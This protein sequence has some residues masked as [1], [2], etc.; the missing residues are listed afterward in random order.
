[1]TVE[2]ALT[3]DARWGVGAPVLV[4][5]A[6]R[7]G[8]AAVGLPW[9][10][11]DVD[12]RAAYADAGVRCHE[13]LALVVSDDEAETLPFAARLAE[14]AETVD[15]EWV[16]AVFRSGPSPD[17][18]KVVAQCAAMI[19]EAGSRMAVEFSP[20]GPITS[21]SAGL[22]L[23]EAAGHGAGLLVDSWHFCHGDS[24]WE[25][26]EQLPLDCVAYIQ[27][28]DAAVAISDDP[29]DETMNRRLMPGTGALELDRFATTLLDRGWDGLVSVEVLNHDL[30]RLPVSEFALLAYE[31][32]VR[33]WS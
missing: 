33:F 30:L 21:I 12:A 4:E 18:S 20:L 25:D 9:R 27:F 10:Q 23:V 17:L 8:F 29:M 14:A 26:L 7:A 31:T 13:L 15:A 32:T 19:A 5:A 24:T 22:E 16:L 11:A 2:L 6:A 28:T 1:M 3:P